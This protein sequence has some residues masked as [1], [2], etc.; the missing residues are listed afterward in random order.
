VNQQYDPLTQAEVAHLVKVL[1]VDFGFC[2]TV[3]AAKEL[4]T[5]PPRTVDAFTQ[6]VFTADGQDPAIA[7]ERF[8]R[9]VESVVA[10]T[11]ERTPVP[12]RQ[13]SAVIYGSFDEAEIRAAERSVVA[14]LEDPDVSKRAYAYTEDAIFCMSGVPVIQGRQEMLSR[15]NTQLFS[16]SL[17][18]EAT[19]GHGNLA[20]VYGHFSCFIGRTAGSAGTPIDRRF[21]MVWRKEADGIW[22]IAKEFLNPDEAAQKRN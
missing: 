8:Y 2:L 1:C 4:E 21:L 22:R 15:P 3:E 9:R 13:D 7:G 17:K 6:A 12:G 11:F 19:E 20:Y 5:N 10:A 16:V 14:L 18:P